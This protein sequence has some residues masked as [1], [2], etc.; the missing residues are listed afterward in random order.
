MESLSIILT[1]VDDVIWGYIVLILIFIGGFYLTFR[2]KFVQFGRI[3][4]AFK[5]MFSQNK[6]EKG[7][8]SAFGALCTALGA[9]VGVGNIVGV[10]TAIC[11]GGPG[12]LF[13]MLIAA[14]FGMATKYSEGVLAIKYRISTKSGYIGG[15]FYYIENGLGKKWK[16]LGVMFAIFGALAC[17]FGIGTVIQS[18]SIT[19]AIND[20][21]DPNNILAVNVFG[22]GDYSLTVIIA[23]LVVAV[24]AGVVLIGGIK[25][26]AVVSEFFVPFMLLFYVAF[27]LM[28]VICNISNLPNALW[29]IFYGAFN[30]SAVTG[31]IVGTFFIALQKGVA[32]G[33]F[34][35][36]AGLGSAPIASAAAKTKEPVEQGLMSMTQTFI[37]T[38]V[39]CMCTGIAIVITGAWQVEGLEG[40][41]VTLH[42]FSTGIPFFHFLPPLVVTVSLVL[43]A[44]TSILG[45]NFYGQ[46]CVEYLCGGRAIFIHLF[47]G[48]CILTI[49]IAPFFTIDAVWTF[50]DIINAL[51]A[52]PNMIALFALSGIVAC[53]TK[54][55]FSK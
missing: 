24:L 8:V 46:K 47:K 27:V 39:I 28:I 12:A 20:F 54:K 43:F 55:Y 14:I 52:F 40:V 7:D 25:R 53:E 4:L 51:M 13:W 2:T 30:P 38:I 48:L 36:E 1:N 45:W 10:A 34:S 49:L 21:F 50:A 19:S 35:N 11:A 18:N 5:L 33:I 3:R 15:P 17:A 9:T 22:I 32:R 29:Q 37:D 31:G 16:W 44:F 23:V 42:A 26:I 41:G 6:N